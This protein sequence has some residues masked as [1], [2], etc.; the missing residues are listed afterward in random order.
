MTTLGV[1]VGYK[2]E[3]L[4]AALRQRLEC[5]PIPAEGPLFTEYDL[6]EEY[7]AS[8]TTVRKA[9]ERLQR[10]GYVVRKTRHG[11]FPG[12]KLLSARTTAT[13]S[14]LVQR[15]ATLASTLD[16]EASNASWVRASGAVRSELKL[17]PNA[18]VLRFARARDAG[19]GALISMTTW[20]A[21]EISAIIDTAKLATTTPI[22]QIETAGYQI[23]EN[24]QRL[25]AGNATPEIAAQINAREGAA[26]LINKSTVYGGNMQ[27][28][29]YSEHCSCAGRFEI[30]MVLRKA[31][32]IDLPDLVR[33]PRAG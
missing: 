28:L 23:S 15:A 10:E 14:G 16:M 21:P 12:A 6:V 2:H 4:Y 9:L 20:F 30:R 8:R 29:S 26:I 27:P 13:V 18:R 7:A 1:G 5:N 25:S 31:G 33:L 3:G 22:S 17:K 32:T 24:V 11:T 19:D